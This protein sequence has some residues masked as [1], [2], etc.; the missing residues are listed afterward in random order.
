MVSEVL[1]RRSA[2]KSSASSR[3]LSTGRCATWRRRPSI[4]PLRSDLRRDR[5]P[6][7]AS[8]TFAGRSNCRRADPAECLGCARLACAI[9]PKY[10]GSDPPCRSGAVTAIRSAR[11][12]GGRC[13]ESST[14]GGR[15]LR[16]LWS[17]RVRRTL[18]HYGIRGIQKASRNWRSA[19]AG[20]LALERHPAGD[21][22]PDVAPRRWHR[23]GC[24]PERLAGQFIGTLTWGVDARDPATFAVTATILATVGALAG[25]LPARRASRSIRLLSC[26]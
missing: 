19:R 14:F 13:H 12:P 25:W 9:D 23:R 22:R 20:R 10:R 15:D 3:T 21:A 24:R 7:A 18:R 11:R 1:G 17:A 26:D 4:H 2:S 8:T 16:S 6:C 5:G